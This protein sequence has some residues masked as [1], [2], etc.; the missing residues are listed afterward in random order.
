MEHLRAGIA[1]LPQLVVGDLGDGGRI[2]HNP[3]VGHEDAGHVRPVF[4]YVRIQRGGGQRAGDVGAAPG[5]GAD[6]AVGHPAVEAG[7]D[8][9]E[10]LV[11]LFQQLIGGALVH[12]AVVFEA[13]PVRRVHESEA[14][15]GGHQPG[16]EIFAPAGQLILA[17]HL[18]VQPAFQGGELGFQIQLDAQLIPDLQIAGADHLKNIGAVHPIL[19][20]GVAQ[21]EQIG[22]LVVAAEALAR[23]GHDHHPPL[24]VG[25]QDIPHL[26]VLIGIRHGAS[27]EFHNFHMISFRPA[28][29]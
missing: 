22:D 2:V 15:I 14:Q 8:H 18:A 13:H 9:A 26:A 16:G 4:V 24:R 27:A 28:P 19:G 20:V 21:V 11:P 17:D 6:L 12:G 5:E 10:A 23:R 1:Q 29:R 3:G 7:N 25:Q